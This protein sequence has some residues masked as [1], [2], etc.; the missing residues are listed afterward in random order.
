[1]EITQNDRE[2]IEAAVKDAE[3]KTSGEIVPLLVQ[4]SGE[5]DSLR[6]RAVMMGAMIGALVSL[7]GVMSQIP[8][9]D[10]FDVLSLDI[11]FL[12]AAIAPVFI[13]GF[14]LGLLST[15]SS[16]L[17]R[18]ILP[19]GVIDDALRARAQRAFLEH[20]IFNTRDRTGILIM[21]SLDEHRVTVLADAGINQKVESSTWDECVEL[22]LSGIKKGHFGQGMANAIR[23]CGDIVTEAGFKVKADDTNEL[24]DSLKVED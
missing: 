1:L 19:P 16:R 4:R 8:S 9:A 15:K 7:L 21:V 3:G 5:Y 6:P 2:E 18:M 17:L 12:T 24:S 13:G 22:V 14:V 10:S 20:E 23:R 11:N